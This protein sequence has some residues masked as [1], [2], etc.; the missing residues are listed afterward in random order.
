M[1]RMKLVLLL[2]AMAFAGCTNLATKVDDDMSASQG[3]V[4]RLQAT[5]ARENV[6]AAA[7]VQVE[8]GVWIAHRAMQLPTQPLPPVFSQHAVFDRMV[9]SL[10]EFAERISIRS[11][12]A[13]EVSPDAVH[14]SQN[15]L[16]AESGASMAW[17]TNTA[18]PGTAPSVLAAPVR[19]PQTGAAL[20]GPVRITFVDGTF[21]GLLDAAAARFG[22]SWR[23][24][25]SAIQFYYTDTRTFQIRAIPGDASL[26]ASVESR[27]AADN[28]GSGSTAANGSA[29]NN[30][31]TT[32]VSSKLSVFDS[33]EKS[34]TAML[35]PQGKAVA[36]PATGSISVTDTPWVLDRVAKF[37]DEENRILS[38]QVMINVTV[39]AVSTNDLDDYGINWDLVYGNISSRFGVQSSFAAQTGAAAFSA[40]ILDTSSSKLAGST[41]MMSALSSQGKVRRETSASV[42]TLNNQ[43]VP[44]QVARQTSFLKS[45][46]TSLTANV[47][48]TTS[49]EPGTVTSGFNMTIL[50]HLMSDG[51]V[52][53][54]FSTD[55]SSL[56]G[57][58]TVTSGSDGAKASIET[59][60]LDTRNF[61]QRVAMHSGETLVISGFEQTD[62][63]VDRKGVGD[64]RFMG[65][66]G[67]FT[68][69]AGKEVIVIL[70]TPIAMNDA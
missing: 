53:L 54:Q 66:G 20:T 32:A 70:V 52:M 42:A 62:S 3:R 5:S 43:P 34:V 30:A 35:S 46:S 4:E 15:A 45:S 55:I 19:A 67:G 18:A 65:L 37:L 26:D 29:R 51:T 31:Q 56:R 25:Q 12:I 21:K 33:I 22:V 7:V 24:A 28:T 10:S 60:E 17:P 41:L 38:R 27:A 61:L 68:A 9:S 23:F 69:G 36:S 8:D 63:N 13:V 64:P 1:H 57:I 49:L 2:S 48:S 50:P 11:G 58:R 6:K 40:A 16:Q 59:P 44:V 39:L 47:G 14:A